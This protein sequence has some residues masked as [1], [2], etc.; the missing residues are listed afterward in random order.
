MWASWGKKW[1][2]MFK[3]KRELWLRWVSPGL[4]YFNLEE[5]EIDLKNRLQ[6][7][8]DF[9]S[10]NRKRTWDFFFSWNTVKAIEKEFFFFSSMSMLCDPFGK[11]KCFLH[12]F[13][14][15][16]HSADSAPSVLLLFFL[17]K[18]SQIQKTLLSVN[19]EQLFFLKYV[20]AYWRSQM[21]QYHL[22]HATIVLGFKISRGMV[23]ELK[24]FLEPNYP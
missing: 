24:H 13:S 12:W 3:R 2:F 22:F 15:H 18:E 7:S 9:G 1:V 20:T 17:G 11:A 10:N 21:D 5:E 8:F 23:S 19:R 4:L 6:V 16:L 14:I